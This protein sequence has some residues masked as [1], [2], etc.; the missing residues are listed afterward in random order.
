VS[1]DDVTV[2][3]PLLLLL[4]PVFP[5]VMSIVVL[6]KRW[7]CVEVGVLVGFVSWSVVSWFGYS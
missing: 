6:Y 2:P 7:G 1:D 5:L 3:L 4:E